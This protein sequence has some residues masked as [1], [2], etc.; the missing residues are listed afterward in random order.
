MPAGGLP[1]SRA[2]P[3]DR[4]GFRAA[5]RCL[6]RGTQCGHRRGLAAWGALG[7]LAVPAVLVGWGVWGALGGPA[8]LVAWGVLGALAVPAVL[9]AW[10]G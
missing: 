2:H 3:A 9:A 4:W 1:A 8:V 5:R 6:C 10:E 7:A